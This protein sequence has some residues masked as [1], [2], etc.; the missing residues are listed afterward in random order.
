MDL[1]HFTA[2]KLDLSKTYYIIFTATASQSA[3]NILA[4]PMEATNNPVDIKV[5]KGDLKIVVNIDLTNSLAT[6]KHKIFK[7]TGIPPMN[8]IIKFAN[9]AFVNDAEV[10]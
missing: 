1:I 6:L 8:Q 10:L 2:P 5:E 4:P 3:D 7:K 9:N